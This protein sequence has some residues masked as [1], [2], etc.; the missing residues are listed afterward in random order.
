MVESGTKSYTHNAELLGVAYTKNE[1]LYDFLRRYRRTRGDIPVASHLEGIA[2]RLSPTIER[3]DE[4]N[5]TL[6][7]EYGRYRTAPGAGAGRH[8]TLRR[9]ASGAH[10]A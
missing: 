6:V 2:N 3:F 7:Q 9:D 10:F 8:V 4:R 5:R 1:Q